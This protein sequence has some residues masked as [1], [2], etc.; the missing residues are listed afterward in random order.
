MATAKQRAARRPS[1]KAT[2]KTTTS[3]LPKVT[4]E[5]K[6]IPTPSDALAPAATTAV[7]KSM[8]DTNRLKLPSV[9]AI[10]KKALMVLRTNPWLFLRLAL[11]YA[12]LNIVLVRGL[13][14]STDLTQLKN[15]MGGNYPSGSD[16]IT[17]ALSIFT[18]LVTASGTTSSDVGGAYQA[19]LTIIMSLAI[20]WAL[21]Q[22]MAG[23]RAVR[24]RDAFYK[25]MYPLI[26]V[27]LVLLVLV[28]QLLPFVLG[29]SV[30][31]VVINNGIAASFIEKALWSIVLFAG[32]LMSLYL[33]SS[34]VI[35][36][37]I[38][39]LPDMTPMKA[40]RSARDLVRY[41]RWTVLRKLIFLPVAL[42][43]VFGVIMVPVILLA[44]SVAPWIFFLLSV[45]GV[46]VAH[47][48]VYSVYRELLA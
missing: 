44:T 38:A 2:K 45:V 17:T 42:F 26:P 46:I 7:G 11:V 6:T 37:Y 47:T 29:G 18:I 3:G 23:D 19:F 16:Q 41:R 30:Y 8:N 9:W 32:L 36:L 1:K 34:S 20:V 40:L 15:L 13:S 10:S 31:G 33:L 5:D 22:V 14:G 39:A 27:I 12:L 43:V 28:L 35:A 25:G 4:A 48:Y 21:R 24:A